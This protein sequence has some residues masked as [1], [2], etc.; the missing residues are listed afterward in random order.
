MQNF[1]SLEILF[2]ILITPSIT[3]GCNFKDI[4]NVSLRL[5]H[6]FSTMG[7]YDMICLAPIG[8]HYVTAAIKMR[9]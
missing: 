5:G 1:L 3:F 9:S 6:D 2:F 8:F 7:Y 4:I